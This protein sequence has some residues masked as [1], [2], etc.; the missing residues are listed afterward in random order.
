M[1][2]V[3]GKCSIASVF[4]LKAHLDQIDGNEGIQNPVNM[5]S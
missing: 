4:E 2:F 1:I 5:N 3:N